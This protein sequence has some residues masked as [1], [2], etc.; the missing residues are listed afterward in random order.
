[1]RKSMNKNF[2]A[3]LFAFASVSAVFAAGTFDEAKAEYAER[4]QDIRVCEDDQFETKRKELIAFIL[5]PGITNCAQH[6]KFLLE[7]VEK[8]AQRVFEKP[9]CWEIA[10][11]LVRDDPTGRRFLVDSKI[12]MFNR[13]TA[14]SRGFPSRRWSPE[15]RLEFAE[16][17]LGTSDFRNVG[18]TEKLA[19]LQSLGMYDAFIA[20]AEEEIAKSERPA[21]KISLLV[22]LAEFHK[23]S[24]KRYYSDPEPSELKKAV[25]AVE[26]ILS[27]E[28]AQKDRNAR[29]AM[30]VA[31]E[32]AYSLGEYAE[33]KRYVA[34]AG[35]FDGD[36]YAADRAAILAKT[37]Y[38]EEDYGTAA[39]IWLESLRKKGQAD[40]PKL[41]KALY[42][43]DRR[44]EAVPFLE[45]MSRKGNKYKRDFYGYALK[46]LRD[47]IPEE[48]PEEAK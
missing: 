19:A 25:A 46:E 13:Y 48:A 38:A 23:W 33:V 7:T 26:R 29:K 12:R 43:A 41:V 8:D 1:M 32:A 35:A 21:D 22:R 27:I 2:S 44:A 28:G 30:I 5:E 31:A 24:S 11:K 42:A 6:V 16:E 14:D 4:L 20:F 47:E 40:K 39:D 34:M 15:A 17:L 10:E 45:E 9:D 3:V 18:R 36:R 37:A